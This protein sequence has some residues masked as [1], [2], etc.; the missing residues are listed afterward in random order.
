MEAVK[1]SIYE[2]ITQSLPQTTHTKGLTAQTRRIKHGI[3]LYKQ[4]KVQLTEITNNIV[5]FK[6]KDMEGKIHDVTLEHGK[7]WTCDCGD[8]SFRLSFCSEIY[9]A[10]LFLAILAD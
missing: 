7:I 10:I 1:K 6:V 5:K 3:E 9:A 2:D 8:H 4:D